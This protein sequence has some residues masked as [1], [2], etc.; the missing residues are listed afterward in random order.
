MGEWRHVFRPGFELWAGA[1]GGHVNVVRWLAENG[2]NLNKA[3]NDG[4]TPMHVAAKQGHVDV[5]RY[6]R[7]KLGKASLDQVTMTVARP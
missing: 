4:Q 5:M 6:L 3:S 1:W 7:E 2:A